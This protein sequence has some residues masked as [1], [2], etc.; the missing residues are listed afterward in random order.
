[1]TKLSFNQMSTVK[2]AHPHCNKFIKQRLVDKKIPN[3]LCYKHWKKKETLR[4]HFIDTN[5]RVVRVKMGLPV[6]RNLNAPK[7]ELH[8][9]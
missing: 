5:Q 4:Y 3:T 9:E 1:M 8:A 6:K 2:C 7:G